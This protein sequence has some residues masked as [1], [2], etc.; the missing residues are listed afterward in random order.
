MLQMKACKSLS[1][2]IRVPPVSAPSTALR[3]RSHLWLGSFLFLILGPSQVKH[4]LRMRSREKS[5]KV[6][7]KNQSVN[8]PSEQ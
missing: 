6:N 1:S 5:R 4:A 3:I 7:L 8:G 2:S